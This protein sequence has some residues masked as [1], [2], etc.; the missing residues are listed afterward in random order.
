VC[1]CVGK[2]DTNRCK[3][4]KVDVPCV[5]YCHTAHQDCDNR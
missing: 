5:V 2:C 4:F 1:K 3:C